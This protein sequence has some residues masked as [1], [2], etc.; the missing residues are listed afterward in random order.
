MQPAEVKTATTRGR[1][2]QRHLRMLMSR[3]SRERG[4]SIVEV[5]LILPVAL[6][7]LAGTVDMGR[8]FFARVAI[9]NAAR[10]GA[11]FAANNPRC[12]T[13]ARAACRDPN[14]VD[15]R[16]RNEATALDGLV[17]TFICF[18][19]N[20]AARGSV[21]D[22]EAGD[23]YQTTV[24]DQF[25]FVTPLLAPIFG[26]TLTLEASATS[27][28]MNTATDPDAPPVAWPTPTPSPTPTPTP[29]PAP[30]TVPQLIGKTVTNAGKAWK[31][32]GFDDK[33]NFSAPGM[34][35]NDV[36]ESQSIPEGAEREC[37]T[38]AITVGP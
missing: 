25:D 26:S 23:T 29:T 18:A 1:G 38:T 36:V 27:R 22:C 24:S 19:P 2:V 28:V 3:R 17:T 20:G 11:V 4:Q 32:A 5:A 37:K 16:V 14:T 15:W 34:K 35:P 31:D 12:D 13:A 33:N 7:L 21:T 8:L 30:C 6:V 10:E 9:E